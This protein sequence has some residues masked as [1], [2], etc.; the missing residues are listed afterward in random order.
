VP[1]VLEAIILGIIQ[2]LTEFLPVSS[3]GH[4]ILAE[5]ALSVSQDEFG[6]RF[7]AALHLGTLA[8]VLLYFRALLASLVVSWIDSIRQRNW[9]ASR[10]SRLA[11]LLLL[12]TLPAG[13]AGYLLESTAEDTFRSPALVGA[14]LILFCIPMV[15][16]E[17]LGRGD[18]TLDGATPRDALITGV[19]QSVAL[20][21]GVSRSGITISAGMLVGF[22]RDEAAVFAFLLSA[23]IIAAAGGKQL[24]DIIR[25]EGG[26]S[27]LENEYLVYAA[28][29]ITAAVVGYA[30]IYF[31]VRYL[32]F[33]PLYLFV[34]YRVAL[35]LLVLTLAAAG[36]L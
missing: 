29:L 24:F 8:A 36:V 17:R 21:P 32:R 4:L 33:N 28:G 9:A 18:R 30:A 25:G 26:S 5:E 16:A 13:I 14:M 1:A 31:L 10:E 15:L 20:V 27:G 22:R 2:G 12:G 7:D 35:G 19:A 6:L 34:V 23:P 3:T 11:W